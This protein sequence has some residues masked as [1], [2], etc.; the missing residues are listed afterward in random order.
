MRPTGD[1]SEAKRRLTVHE[2][3]E[4]LDLT[5]EAVRSRVRRGSLPSER[6]ED[7]TVYV[8][9]D[10][11][12]ADRP[13]DQSNDQSL[14]MERLDSEVR[15]LREELARR[16]EYLRHREESWVEE[17]RRKDSII[18]ALTQR[19]PELEPASEPREPVASATQSGREGKAP[20]DQEKATEQPWW[21]RWFG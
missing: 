10:A 20:E 19:I 12:R 2:A 3:A 9:V 8:L 5:S 7:G 15:F 6:G 16:D 13:H 14:I 1:A 18:A 21:R 4:T 17:S 11:D